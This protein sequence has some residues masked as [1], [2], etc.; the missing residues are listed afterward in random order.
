MAILTPGE[1]LSLDTVPL[2]IRLPANGPSTL[3]ETR[4]AAERER[5]L[6]ALEDADWNVSAA[7]RALGLERTTLHKRIRSLGVKRDIWQA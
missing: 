4:D 7:A 2:E 3:R 5:I 6:H 1:T